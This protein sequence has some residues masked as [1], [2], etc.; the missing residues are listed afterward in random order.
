M[1]I[2]AIMVGLDDSGKTSIINRLKDRASK[3]LPPT[4]TTI[5]TTFYFSQMLILIQYVLSNVLE[6]ET[7]A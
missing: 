1:C 2:A 3:E 5:G 4:R 6:T 7:V